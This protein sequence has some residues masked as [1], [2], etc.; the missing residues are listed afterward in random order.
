VRPRLVIVGGAPGT[1]KTTLAQTLAA[2]LALPLIAKDD[3]KE[4]LADVLGA[5]DQAR[6]RALGAAAMAVMRAVAARSLAAGGALLLEANF[7]RDLSTPWLRELA[8]GADA[9]VIICR[10]SEAESRRR[11]A[12]RQRHAV[13][14]DAEI[15]AEP[16]P[17]DAEFSLDLGVPALVVDTTDGCSPDLETIVRFTT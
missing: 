14:L 13:H 1:G 11:F 2:R 3:I 15:L 8:A 10:A 17:E 16:W 12:D 7:H 4:A 6:S 9:R 5:G